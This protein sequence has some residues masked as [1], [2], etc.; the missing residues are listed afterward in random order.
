M[1]LKAGDLVRY[2]PEGELLTVGLV[3]RAAD[4]LVPLE[5][6]LEIGP[7]RGFHLVRTATDLDHVKTLFF[8]AFGPFH[9]GSRLAERAQ[10]ELA[11]FFARQDARVR[12]TLREVFR[13]EGDLLLAQAE[14][15]RARHLLN[16]A[17]EGRAS[18]YARSRAM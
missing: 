11:A 4:R 1:E 12:D 5:R 15:D 13:R 9:G 16:E 8:M 14:L 18:R 2:G 7:L 3:D 17:L 6:R 10:R